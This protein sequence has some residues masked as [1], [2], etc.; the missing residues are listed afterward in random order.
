MPGRSEIAQPT[1]A[2]ALLHLGKPAAHG[3]QRDHDKQPHRV[4]SD[5]AEP[6]V[7]RVDQPCF[8]VKKR[9]DKKPGRAA[10]PHVGDEQGNR[11]DQK[12]VN[13]IKKKRY[14]AE[15]DERSPEFAE[16]A[17]KQGEQDQGRA[18]RHQQKK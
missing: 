10:V 12:N 15:N 14:P 7:W 18:K 17:I 13:D 2:S 1:P 4:D 16:V 11:M 8:I 6:V 3:I 5:E 9:A